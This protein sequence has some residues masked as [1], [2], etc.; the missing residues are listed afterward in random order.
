[1]QLG[2]DKDIEIETI[3]LDPA[4]GKVKIVGLRATASSVITARAEQIALVVEALKAKDL[5]QQI[6]AIEELKTQGLIGTALADAA[7]AIAK[8]VAPVPIP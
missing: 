6:A 8:A 2:S 1:M 5:K 4:T 7:I 3:D